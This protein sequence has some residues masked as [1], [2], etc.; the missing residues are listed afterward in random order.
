MYLIMKNKN[1]GHIPKDING[2]VGNI[3]DNLAKKIRALLLNNLNR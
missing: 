3:D 1:F 2:A